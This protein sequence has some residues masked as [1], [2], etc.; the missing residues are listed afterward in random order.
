MTGPPG[1]VPPPEKEAAAQA[2]T[3][4]ADLKAKPYQKPRHDNTNDPDYL[5]KTALHLARG[6]ELHEFL[7]KRPEWYRRVGGELHRYLAARAVRAK[8]DPSAEWP[9]LHP[10]DRERLKLVH[11]L[12]LARKRGVEIGPAYAAPSQHGSLND[13]RRALHAAFT[14]ILADT[15]AYHS[16]TSRIAA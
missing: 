5:V 6:G 16:A 14:E 13:A 15:L 4:A 12:A 9:E 10:L 3:G 7:P 8:A 2:G 1:G 11:Q